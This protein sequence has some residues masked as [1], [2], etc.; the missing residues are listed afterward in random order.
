MVLVAGFGVGGMQSLMYVNPVAQPLAYVRHALITLPVMIAAVLTV[1]PP[2]A[3]TFTPALLLPLVL[4]GTVLGLLFVPAVWPL[5]RDTTLR[6]ALALTVVAL[7]PQ[8]ATDASE[9]LLYYPFVGASYALA[10]VI[11]Q[12]GPM[13]RLQPA[14]CLA[15]R[16]TRMWGWYLLGGVVFPG[17]VIAALM[18]FVFVPSLVRPNRD[19]ASAIPAVRAHLQ[20][21]PAGTIVML[22]LAGPMQTFYASGILE[23]H[24]RRPVPT[25]VLSALNGIVSIERLDDRSFTLRTDR[26]GWLDNMFARI[27]RVNAGFSAGRRYS[28]TDFDA[29]LER[30]TPGG[31]DVLDVRFD[32][33]NGLADGNLLFL[34]WNGERLV[35]IDVA[36][37]PLSTRMSLADTSDVWKSM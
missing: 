33:H 22:N 7:L 27:V 28:N 8:V 4:T 5:R 3:A 23:Y 11:A 14:R 37:L 34:S 13:A 20:A 32:F 29:T 16:F 36:S 19:V 18:P 1:V 24:L 9:R 12:V 2:S 15:P 35:R 10:A 21:H 31:R 26:S 25:R 6:W 30:L 17:L